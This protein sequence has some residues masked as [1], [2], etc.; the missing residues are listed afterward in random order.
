MLS[1]L[2]L[3]ASS[4]LLELVL[5]FY[6]ASQDVLNCKKPCLL[7]EQVTPQPLQSPNLQKILKNLL[8]ALK[9]V[10]P[11]LALVLLIIWSTSPHLWDQISSSALLVRDDL[12][13]L[14]Y[15]SNNLLS[16]GEILDKSLTYNNLDLYSPSSGLSTPSVE[17][18][19]VPPL[20]QLEGEFTSSLQASEVLEC[21]TTHTS[22]LLTGLVLMKL[23]TYFPQLSPVFSL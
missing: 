21:V 22:W 8:P 7:L 17:E 23:N 12:A 9:F 13:G 11:S 4:E 20:P 19:L 18:T 14:L 3:V 15:L 10:V 5:T 16:S 6:G 1:P 2:S